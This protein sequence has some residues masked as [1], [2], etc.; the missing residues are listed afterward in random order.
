MKLSGGR[1][2][3]LTIAHW[4]LFGEGRGAK[5]KGMGCKDNIYPK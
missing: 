4:L 5:G 1:S 2:E 3:M